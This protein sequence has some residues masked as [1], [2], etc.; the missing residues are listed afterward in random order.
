MLLITFAL[1]K[2][3]HR[4]SWNRLNFLFLGLS[5]GSCLVVGSRNF[6]RQKL[7]SQFYGPGFFAPFA[8]SSWFGSVRSGSGKVVGVP[9]ENQSCAEL[10]FRF[11]FFILHPRAARKVGPEV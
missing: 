1:H 8:G 9:F 6:C 2:C 10:R 5:C 11:T 7:L 3:R 4:A